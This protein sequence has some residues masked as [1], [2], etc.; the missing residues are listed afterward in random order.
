MAANF[1]IA[2]VDQISDMIIRMC[3]AMVMFI[4]VENTPYD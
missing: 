1:C 4:F 3:P 2:G